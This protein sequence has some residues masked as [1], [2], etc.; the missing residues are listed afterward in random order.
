MPAFFPKI[1]KYW[2]GKC[3]YGAKVQGGGNALCNKPANSHSWQG[4]GYNPGFICAKGTSFS[5]TLGGKNGAPQR[6]YDFGVMLLGDKSG[7]YADQM[8]KHCKG[9]GM[10]PVCE[11][12][13]YCFNDQA[14]IFIG[15]THHL[16][17]PAHRNNNKYSPSGF[18]GIRNNWKGLCNY[19]AKVQGG[20]NALCNIPVNS[21]SWQ[22]TNRNPGFMCARP[23]TFHATLVGKNGVKTT[24]YTFVKQFL[25]S[26]SGKYSSQMILACSKL[27]MK[28][29]C[30]HPSYC[31]NNQDTVYLGQTG[32][33]S[34][35][36]HR[37]SNK[38]TPVGFAAIRSNWVGMCNYAARVN[39]GGNALCNHPRNSHSWQGTGHNAGFICGVSGVKSFTAYLAGKNGAAARNYHFCVMRLTRT[40]GKFADLMI[41]KC[42]EAG[43]KPVCEHPSYCQKDTKSLYIGQAHHLSY[44][45]HRNAKQYFPS[46]WMFVKDEWAGLCN[47]AA[48]VQGGGN[49]LCNIPVNSHSWQAQNINMGFMCGEPNSFEGKLGGKNGVDAR[50][51]EFEIG[52]LTTRSGKY[53]DLMS[54]ACQKYG[55]KPDVCDHRA[56]CRTDPNSLFLG[57]THHISYRPHRVNKNYMPSGF[58]NIQ[59]YFQGMCVYAAKAN[60]GRALCNI[61]GNSHSWQS[62]GSANPGFVCGGGKTFKA[63]IAGKNGVE[64]KQYAF[65]LTYLSSKS[66]KYAGTRTCIRCSLSVLCRLSGTCSAC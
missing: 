12:R 25:L 51:Y 31:R 44:P 18:S 3:N 30:E 4:T 5:R 58:S 35:P 2:T 61:P 13:S 22:G 28:P 41:E 7:K 29:V 55:M 6:D 59:Q 19:A 23:R 32:H 50:T 60:A 27:R 33:F 62:A 52:M 10:K 46:G 56:Y 36:A 16:S 14:S 37:N 49:A 63:A 45:P 53:S 34:Y 43:M 42:S 1:R 38:Y 48:K 8:I 17:Y 40:N 20:G 65:E 64:A 24:E 11:H 47:Y 21:H 26:R 54:M 66:G 39:G 57:Q 15:Q 9:I